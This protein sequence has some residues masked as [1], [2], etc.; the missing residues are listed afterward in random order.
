MHYWDFWKKQECI[1]VGCVP[2]AAVAIWGGVSTKNPLLL[3]AS[4]VVAFCPPQRPYQKAAFNQKATKPEGHNRRPQQKAITEGHTPEQATPQNQAPPWDQAPPLGPGTP[5]GAGTPPRTRHPPWD[6][7]PPKEENPPPTARH[8]RIPPA[9]HAGIPPPPVNRIT[10]MCKNLT[11][12][13][14][15]CGR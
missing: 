13:Q 2:P 11:L 1:P 15:R 12:P 6:Q 14:R 8:A 10:N 9:M 5:L 7:A 3:G 4:G